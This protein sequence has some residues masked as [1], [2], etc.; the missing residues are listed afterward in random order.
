MGS[1]D[2][3]SDLDFGPQ[4]SRAFPMMISILVNGESQAVAAEA[5][6]SDL[7]KQLK[8]NPKFLAVELNRHVVPR[9]QHD[10]VTLNA[11]DQLEIVTLVG[12][13]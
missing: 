6:V 4:T 7:L 13:G 5:T 12:G 2:F 8:M 10:Q 3:G 1:I 11:N 9:G